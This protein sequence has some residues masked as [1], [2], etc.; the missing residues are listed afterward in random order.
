M[1]S[2]CLVNYLY[3]TLNQIPLS[4]KVANRQEKEIFLILF[5]FLSFFLKTDQYYDEYKFNMKER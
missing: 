2:F 4:S 5:F 3:L 1:H